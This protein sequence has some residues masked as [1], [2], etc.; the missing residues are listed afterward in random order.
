MIDCA[1]DM[2]CFTGRIPLVYKSHL[3]TFSTGNILEFLHKVEETQVR[4][5]ASSKGLHAFEVERFKCNPIIPVCKV[6][7]KFPVE[8]R[9]LVCNLTVFACKV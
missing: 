4:Y 7:G 2:A 5:L 6:V 3:S 1:T 9:A 8:I